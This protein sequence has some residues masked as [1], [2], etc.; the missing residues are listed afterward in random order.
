MAGIKPDWAIKIYQVSGSLVAVA[1]AGKVIFYTEGIGW[2][3]FPE[4]FH[5][6]FYGILIIFEFFRFQ[7]F[8]IHYSCVVKPI[9]IIYGFTQYLAIVCR[10]VFNGFLSHKKPWNNAMLLEAIA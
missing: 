10:I 5:M 4:L 6:L 2:V 7:E 1:N 3:P 9:V 8:W